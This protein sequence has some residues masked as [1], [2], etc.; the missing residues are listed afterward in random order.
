MS[1][2]PMKVVLVDDDED[3]RMF[4]ADALQEIDLKTDLTE[5]HNGQE[6]L[7]YLTGSCTEFPQ[8]IFLDLNMPVMDGFECLKKIRSNPK[9]EDLVV[10]IYSTSS[11]ERD[12][13]E[14]FVNG[15]NI[16]INKP[17]KFEELKKTIAQV[18]KRNWQYEE[19][20]MDKGNFLFRI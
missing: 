8:L 2:K 18:V 10:A 19:N 1:T 4:F 9:F 7:D 20:E 6:L 11:S 15:A 12:I 3:D 14:T 13:E 16:Y 5:F 17:N